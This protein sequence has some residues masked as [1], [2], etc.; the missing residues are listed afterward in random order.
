MQTINYYLN[1]DFKKWQ[2]NEFII[3]VNKEFQIDLESSQ[4][5]SQLSSIKKMYAKEIFDNGKYNF[6]MF[7]YAVDDFF[8]KKED[9][10]LKKE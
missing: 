1:L 8:K 4:V 5:Q 3:G 6:E 2:E 10:R 9:E 7:K